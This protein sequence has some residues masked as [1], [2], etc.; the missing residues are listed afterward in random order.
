[1]GGKIGDMDELLATMKEARDDVQKTR[2]SERTAK[3]EREKEKE[4]IS[5][6]LLRVHFSIAETETINKMIKTGMREASRRKGAEKK[7]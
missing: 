5:R 7:S 3:E 4:I 6:S 1:M 2:T